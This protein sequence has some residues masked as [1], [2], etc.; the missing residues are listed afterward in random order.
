MGP[1]KKMCCLLIKKNQSYC[2]NTINIPSHRPV[3]RLAD[4]RCKILRPGVSNGDKPR[5]EGELCTVY[6][7]PFQYTEYCKNERAETYVSR[8]NIRYGSGPIS[9]KYLCVLVSCK[10]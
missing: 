7:Q 9:R 8:I 4:L 5:V 10:L 1:N 2:N 3:A 6:I